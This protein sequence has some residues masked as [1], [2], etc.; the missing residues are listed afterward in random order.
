MRYHIIDS[1]LFVTTRS[2][3]YS[4][5]DGN[6]SSFVTYVDLDI[7]FHHFRP[8]VFEKALGDARGQYNHYVVMPFPDPAVRRVLAGFDQDRLLLLDINFD[9]PGKR[10]ATVSQ[11]HDRELIAALE[12]AA[13][14]IARYDGM[15]L[16]FPN[17][18]HHPEVIKPAEAEADK[19]RILAQAE[20]E[21]I[22]IQAA[23]AA[24]HDRVAL[25]RMLIDQLPQIV[26]EAANGLAGANVN[27]LNGAEGLGEL[28]AGLVA[29]GLTILDSVKRNLAAS[30]TVRADADPDSGDGDGE[31]GE[32]RAL[33]G[34][35]V[36][37]EATR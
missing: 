3:N 5:A 36:D 29:Q 4:I 37:G 1:I 6:G 11:S 33:P 19:V 27:V 10:C 25:D 18:K 28:T 22:R 20:A 23:A 17:D 7:H 34:S 9:F 15:V 26:K 35:S 8:D 12:Q 2:I 31:S 30:P 14:R 24:S 13:A 16:V 21:R 32:T